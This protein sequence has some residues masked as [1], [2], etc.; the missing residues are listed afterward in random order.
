MTRK[1]LC[2]W[3]PVLLCMVLIFWFSSQNGTASGEMS[4]GVME[5]L[6]P[7]VEPLYGHL[8]ALQQKVFLDSFHTL[9]RKT[10]HV[11]IYFLL[12][13]S[14]SFAFGN[15]SLSPARKRTA[16]LLLS[17]LYACSDELHQ[18]FVAGRGPAVTDVLIDTAGAALAIGLVWG[19]GKL[20]K[21]KNTSA[22]K[23]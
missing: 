9:I 22:P 16:S 15:Y 14:A 23:S 11:S 20:K 18:G 2:G 7:L 21:R 8:P 17:F 3:I 13:L 5:L 10:A 1:Q 6:D 19:I 4:H 12:G